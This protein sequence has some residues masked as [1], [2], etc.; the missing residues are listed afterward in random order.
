MAPILGII[1]SQQPGHIA[2]GSYESI[3]TY[4]TT[5]SS[6]TFS[7]IP[8]TYK[9]LQIRYIG[10]TNRADIDDTLELRMNGNTGSSY[11]GHALTGNG[12]TAYSG[13]Q[14]LAASVFAGR[15]AGNSATSGVFAAGVMDILDYTDTNKNRTVRTLSGL[16]NNGSGY[17][18]LFSSLYLSTTTV[19][20]ITL[21]MGYGTA[22]SSGTQFA[23][24]G[25]KG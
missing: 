13:A 25:I 23:L 19:T 6:I 22:F 18:T 3:A 24:Y 7:S 8:Q 16:D 2:T 5:A 11:V 1:A 20:S 15:L 10:R 4:N 17:M 12:S 14:G 9:H 21:Y